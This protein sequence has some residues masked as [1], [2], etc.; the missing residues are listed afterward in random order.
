MAVHLHVRQE[1]NA[2]PEKVFAALID[3]HAAGRWLPGCSR[4]E[5]LTPQPYAKGTR[6]RETRR[7]NGHEAT[8][9]FEVTDVDANR[10]IELHCDGRKGSSGNVDYYFRY[11]LAHQ[12]QGTL[13]TLDGRM[14]P[15]GWFG[16]I[17]APLMKYDF[18]QAL[19][20][21]HMALKA[22]VEKAALT[23]AGAGRAEA[24]P[25]IRPAPRRS[26]V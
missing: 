24:D 20:R 14:E 2:P 4:L 6:W 26:R 21:D 5:M 7:E 9:E 3:L 15:A 11:E 25:Q 10:A 19:K 17:M 8:Q 23:A 18:Q 16:W 22:Y 1:I 12:G 13:L